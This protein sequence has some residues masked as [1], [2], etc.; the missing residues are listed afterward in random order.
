ME[1]IRVVIVPLN[2]RACEL[3]EFGVNYTDKL[4]SDF[5]IWKISEKEYED[6]YRTTIFQKINNSCNILIDDY[7]NERLEYD[8]TDIALEEILASEVSKCEVIVRLTDMI[9][10]AKEHKTFVEFDF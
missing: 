2:Q 7:E 10:T 1:K 4:E 3:L 8:L 6:L 9:R 5:A